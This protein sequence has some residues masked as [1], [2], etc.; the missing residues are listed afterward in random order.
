M[1]TITTSDRN[2]LYDAIKAS[3]TGSIEVGVSPSTTL[4]VPEG[5]SASDFSSTGATPDL[6][7]KPEI[8]APGGAVTSATPGNDYDNESGTAEASAQAAAV[9]TLVRQRMAT[10]P[11][12][13]GLS[14]AEKNAVVTKLPDGHRPPDRGRAAG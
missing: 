1:G 13:A 8:A 2:R 12:F 10:D 11:A 9:A 14:D 5:L 3:G 7:L 4:T 6:R